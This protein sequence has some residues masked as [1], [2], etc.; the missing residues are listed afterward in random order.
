MFRILNVLAV[1]A[2]IGSAGYAYQ[3]KYE[4]SYYG[5]Q[6]VK[7]RHLIDKERDNI[8]VLKAEWAHLVRPERL[9]GLSDKFLDLKAPSL[10]QVVRANDLPIKAAKVDT[11]GRKLEA[12]GLGQPTNTPRNGADMPQTTPPAKAR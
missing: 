9:Q 4:T 12:L 5:E 2:L 1:L 8:G 10:L 3:I 6:I 7:M 11:I